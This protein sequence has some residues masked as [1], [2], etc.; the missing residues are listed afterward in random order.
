MKELE[1]PTLAQ[2]GINYEEFKKVEVKMASDA[3]ASGSPSNTRRVPEKEDI[4][5]IYEKL[6]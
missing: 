2:Y 1:V 3:I 6:W 5:R 4:I